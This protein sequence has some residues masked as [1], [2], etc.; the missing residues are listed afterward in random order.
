MPKHIK[1]LTASDYTANIEQLGRLRT[2]TVLNA[3]ASA[4]LT[5]KTIGAIDALLGCLAE[6]RKSTK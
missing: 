6:L 2:A 1:A 4:E 3:D 5:T